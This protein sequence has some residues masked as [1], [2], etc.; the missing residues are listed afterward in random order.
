MRSLFD[1]DCGHNQKT[2]PCRDSVCKFLKKLSDKSD[3]PCTLDTYP[4]V[5]L[6][7]KGTNT[8][9]SLG[10][11]TAPTVFTLRKFNSENC[12]VVLTFQESTAEG[13]VARPYVTDCRDLAGVVL[14]NNE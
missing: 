3:S 5:L 4:L 11:T 10:G 8:P 2:S 1:D 9:L 13:E 7:N 12:G 6:I 14:L